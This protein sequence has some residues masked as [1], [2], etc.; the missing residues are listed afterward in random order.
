[1]SQNHYFYTTYS[2]RE[3]EEVIESFKEDFDVF[4][5][6]MFS[7]E[8]LIQYE[9]WIDG[10]SAVYVQPLLSELSFDDFYADSEREDEQRSFF[11]R[12]K[13]SLGLENIPFLDSNPIQVTYLLKLLDL[14]PELL[15]D[16]GG[17]IEL[18]FKS[19][20]LKDILKYKTIDSLVK[21]IE[22]PLEVKT[23]RPVD[24]IDFLILDVYKELSR[25]DGSSLTPGDL[26]PKVQKIYQV[27]TGEKLDSTQLL[28]KVGLNAKDFDDGLE[29]L[30]FWLKKR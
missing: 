22:K 19:D 4:L 6:D 5:N 28:R 13:S 11:T 7:D 27:M 12:V 9:K 18:Q 23:T 17:V 3:L 16:R 8:E 1:M 14:F 2:H 24:P 29:R 10:L 15:I 20:Y 30:K 26:S 21:P 25:L